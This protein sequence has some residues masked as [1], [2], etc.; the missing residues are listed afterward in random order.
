LAVKHGF[1]GLAAVARIRS[2]RG[3]DQDVERYFPADKCFKP[4][5]IL[6]IVREH[7]GIENH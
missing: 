4:Q 2:R 6:R 5:E 3:T 1:A 7:W